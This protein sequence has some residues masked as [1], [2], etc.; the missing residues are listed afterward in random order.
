MELNPTKRRAEV[1]AIQKHHN[2]TSSTSAH[3]KR[4]ARPLRLSAEP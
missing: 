3:G 1:A 4:L 2:T